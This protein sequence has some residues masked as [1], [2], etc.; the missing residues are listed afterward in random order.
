M[1]IAPESL[2]SYFLLGGQMTSLFRM[3]PTTAT[4]PTLTRHP[5]ISTA[6]QITLLN[7][8]I[9][10]T[11][12]HTRKEAQVTTPMT[13]RVTLLNRMIPSTVSHTRKETQVTTPMT[14]RAL[15]Q[16]TTQVT[17]PITTRALSQTTAQA[18]QPGRSCEEKERGGL[19]VSPL[20]EQKESRWIY[21]SRRATTS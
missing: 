20:A 10:S 12:S 14:M 19:D 2:Q 21:N 13:M 9:P 18:L 16:I 4:T 8:T 3:V 17:T 11:V 15:S 1:H 5:R 6:V 7:R